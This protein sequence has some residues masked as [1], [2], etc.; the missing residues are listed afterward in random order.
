[1]STLSMTEQSE[2][3]HCFGTP[4]QCYAEDV[5]ARCYLSAGDVSIT[6]IDLGGIAARS[7]GLSE[8]MPPVSDRG[9][10]ASRAGVTGGIAALNR[11]LLAATPAGV[12]FWRVLCFATLLADQLRAW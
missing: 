5:L 11:R 1:M 12:G 7:Q 4:K 3:C 9:V 10:I 6:H 8:A 2:V